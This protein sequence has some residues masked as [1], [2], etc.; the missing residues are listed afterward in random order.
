M[1]KIAATAAVILLT[2]MN[3]PAFA[4]NYSWI[5]PTAR[6]RP[7][8]V[9]TVPVLQEADIAGLRAALNLTPAQQVHWLPVEAVLNDLVR[10]QS[11]AEASATARRWRGRPVAIAITAAELHRLRS[12]AMPLIKALTDGQKN[13]AIAFVQRMGYGSL[14]TMF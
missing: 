6:P 3:A 11:R 12:S 1:P 8:Y 14:L 2:C 10:W 4:Q 7:V 5:G 9:A 13:A